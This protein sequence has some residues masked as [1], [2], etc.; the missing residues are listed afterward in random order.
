MSTIYTHYLKRLFDLAV[1]LL[2]LILLTIPLSLLALLI[3]TKMGSPVLFTQKRGGYRCKPFSIYKFRSMTDATDE[4]GKL[5]PDSKRITAL[6]QFLRSSSLDELPSLINLI[7][8]DIGLVGPR[9]FIYDYMELY[10]PHYC[11]RHD[12]RPGITGWAQVKGRNAI[13]W[14]E[15][16]EYDLWYVDHQSF[17]LDIKILG[18]TAKKLVQR[19]DVN[20]G[21]NET[22]PRYTGSPE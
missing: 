15:K 2:L 19:G 21:L 13:S 14:E 18:M 17:L 6:G 3:R 7:R 22:M 8:G 5:L 10:P 16:F 9:P 12:A 20:S 4:T 11:R 1:G